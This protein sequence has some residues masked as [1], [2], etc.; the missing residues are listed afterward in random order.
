MAKLTVCPYCNEP[1]YDST[2]KSR[3]FFTYVHLIPQLRAL[4]C[5]PDTANKMRYRHLFD[6]LGDS[7]SDIFHGK[8][9]KHLCRTKVVIDGKE[10][11]YF[12]FEEEHEIALGLCTDGMCPFKRRKQTCWPIVLVNYNLPPEER[13]R[14]ENLIC[15][16][17]VPGPKCPADLN[18]CLQPL[19]EELVELAQGT[20]VVD[21][22]QR[23]LFSLR[24][25][26]ITI[27]GNIPV[28]T[29]ILEFIGHNSCFPCRFCMMPTVSSATSGGGTHHYCPLHQPNGHWTDPLNLL[30]RT[31][32]D[33]LKQGL[34]VLH[35]TTDHARNKLASKS[36]VKGVTLL[37]CLSSVSIP[38]SF[39]VDLMHMIWQNLIPQLINLWTKEST[40]LD[41]GLEDY[42]IDSNVWDV[43]GKAC[44]SSGDILPSSFG[45]RVPHFD[46]H[47]QFIAETWSNFTLLLSPCILH[48]RFKD[49]RYYKHFV[50]LV[51]LLRL[52]ISFDLPREEID[53][54]CHGLV[55]WVDEHE[56]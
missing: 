4:F 38:I 39:P 50:C 10:Q 51:K 21:V 1:C 55:D 34:E 25:H 54:I 36:G 52:I 15:V 12:Y 28:I 8:H 46:K 48:R 2:G 23:K 18:S 42:C 24:A 31:H 11:P 29:K 47:S 7:I 9:Y 27:F 13:T 26:L 41:D 17:V 56:Q 14:T 45:C 37:A 19:I 22:S 35:A 49:P 20:A 30:L 3:N 16:G 33:C 6:I 40:E 32:D 5:C 43:I 44:Q 53:T